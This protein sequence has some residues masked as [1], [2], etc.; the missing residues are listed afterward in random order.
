MVD[1]AGRQLDPQGAGQVPEVLGGLDRKAPRAFVKAIPRAR[2][3][4][5]ALLQCRLDQ[6]ED[7]PA[8][9]KAHLRGRLAGP[10][11]TITHDACLRTWQAWWIHLGG[12]EPWTENQNLPPFPPASSYALKPSRTYSWREIQEWKSRSRSASEKRWRICA[13]ASQRRRERT[14]PSKLCLQQSR[15]NPE[16]G[17]K[18]RNE[19][20][21]KAGEGTASQCSAGSRARHRW[22][23]RARRRGEGESEQN[24]ALHHAT[25]LGWI[26]Q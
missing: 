11:I 26:E 12:E 6:P 21:L 20:R 3:A 19:P 2:G 13:A 16:P 23:R 7:E 5:E 10:A 17:G 8:E 22:L 14:C 15:G 1:P 9:A 24:A 18:A 25:S 4:G